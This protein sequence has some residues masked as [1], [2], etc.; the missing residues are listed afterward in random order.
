MKE[1][2]DEGMV[3]HPSTVVMNVVVDVNCRTNSIKKVDGT[4]TFILLFGGRSDCR[5]CDCDCDC[6][7][8]VVD[9][10]TNWNILPCCIDV[11]MVMLI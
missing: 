7:L 11:S 4:N 8:D 3:C 10:G 6:E 9:D 5:C 1:D 2:E